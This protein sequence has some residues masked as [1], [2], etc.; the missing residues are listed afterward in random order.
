MLGTGSFMASAARSPNPMRRPLS[1]VDDLMIDGFH[2]AGRHAPAFRGGGLQ[3]HARG[4][5][6]LAHRHQIMPGAARSISVLVAISDFVAMRLLD[7]NAR[8][9]GFHL[10]GDD[11]WQA[12]ANASAH[13]GTMRDDGDNSVGCDCHEHTRVD[14]GTV[15]HL[16]RTGLVGCESMAAHDRSGEHETS[17]DLRGPSARCG[18]KRSQP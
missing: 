11:Q 18:A 16:A 6:N 13:L 4:R 14:D 9:I 3:H 12:G 17:R 1:L 8:P 2:L 5:A 15:R 7:A 10:F